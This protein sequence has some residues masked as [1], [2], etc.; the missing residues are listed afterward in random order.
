[1]ETCGNCPEMNACEKLGMITGD[2]A[3]ALCRLKEQE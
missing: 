1:V 2:N 3:D